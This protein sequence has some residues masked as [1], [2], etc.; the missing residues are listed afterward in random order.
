MSG[1][2]KLSFI[3]LIGVLPCAA[4][5][6]QQVDQATVGGGVSIFGPFVEG[7]YMFEPNLRVRGVIIGGWDFDT[8]ETDDSGNSFD[9]DIDPAAAA[10][11]IDHY[12]SDTGLRFSGGLFFD[13]SELTAIGRPSATETF[14]FNGE[15]FDAGQIVV[16]AGFSAEVAPMVTVGYEYDLEE[17]LVFSGE[18]GAI[19]AGGVSATVVADNDPL[20]EAIDEDAD[21]QDA[22]SEAG[23]ISILPYLSL[24]I[25]YRF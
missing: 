22:L 12:P 5:A 20:Q 1:F 14:E 7:T 16:D 17:Q 23:N 15:T 25:S 24:S 3:G 19:Y 9:L 6:D 11:L 13:M 21:F 2:R 4:F 10:I 8:S 18:V